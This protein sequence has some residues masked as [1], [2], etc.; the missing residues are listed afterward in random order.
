MP[1]EKN[2]S[3]PDFETAL[4]EL[5]AL[6]KQM[7]AGDLTLEHSLQNFEKGIQLTRHCQQ[8]LAN[9]ELRVKTLMQNGEEVEFQTVESTTV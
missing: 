5:E 6:V 9:A 4:I 8:A 3:S 7:E 1:V 2:D